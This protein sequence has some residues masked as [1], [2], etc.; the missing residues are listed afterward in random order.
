LVNRKL[1]TALWIA[2]VV[3]IAIA[4]YYPVTQ[5]LEGK[6]LD[7]EMLK[8]RRMKAEAVD[9][10]PLSEGTDQDADPGRTPDNIADPGLETSGLGAGATIQTAGPEDSNGSPADRVEKPD[11]ASTDRTTETNGITAGET[12]R[13]AE[14]D[15]TMGA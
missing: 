13:M 14:S 9:S 3:S 10:T 5:F 15:G 1:R 11:E 12:D 2:A 4:L 6:A 8:L 7:D